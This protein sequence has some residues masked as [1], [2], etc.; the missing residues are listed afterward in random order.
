M[1]K[2]ENTTARQAEI[3][4]KAQELLQSMT[5]PQKLGQIMAMFAGGLI[6]SSILEQFTCGLGE[7]ALL[8]TPDGKEQTARD[9]EEIQKIV[10]SACGLPAIVHAEALTG[11]LHPDATI[12]PSAIGLGA[13]WDTGLVER[14]TE[15]IRVQMQAVGIYQ[16][17]SPV[18]DVARDPRWGRVGETYGEDP[19]LCAAMSVAFTKGLQGKPG[20]DGVIA[21]GKHFLG[22]AM[23]QAGLN[24]AANSIPAR[25]LREIYAKP[26]QAAITEAGLDSVMNSYGTIDNEMVIGSKKIL[27]DL[28]RDE[29]GFE[30]IVVSDYMSIDRMVDLKTAASPAEGGIRALEAGLDSE[31][32][33]PFGYGPELLQAIADGR[34]DEKYLDRAVS[35]I[36]E[37]KLKYGLLEKADAKTWLQ[38]QAFDVEKTRAAS[39]EA[40]RKSIVLLKND[41]ILPLKKEPQTI[42]LIGPHADSLR[43]L[44]GCYTYPAQIDRDMSGSMADMPGMVGMAGTADNAYQMSYLEGCS[45]R[46]TSPV[47]EQTLQQIYG[48]RTPTLLKS[49]KDKCPEAT[50]LYEKGCEVAGTDRSGFEAALRAAKQ[51][52]IMIVCMGGKYGWGTNCTTGE[53][54]DCDR[55]GL[56]GVQEELAQLLCET[57]TPAVFV[58]MDAKPLCSEW[59]A[60]NYPAVIENWFPGETGGEALMDVLFGD[61]NPAGRLP[62]TAPRNE[63]QIPIFHASQN[64]SGYTPG[65]GMVISKYVEGTKEPLFYF[66]EGLSYTTFQYANLDV[67][68]SVEPDGIV[69]ISAEITNT[70]NLA[71]D[72]VVQLYVSDEVASMVRPQKEL[73]GFCR[74]SLQPGQTKKVRFSMKASQF[75]FLNKDMQWEVEEGIMTVRV[76]GSSKELP[77]SG[78]FEISKSAIVD[79]RTRGFYANALVD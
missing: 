54:I 53:G 8:I 72:E 32:P 42:A 24:M 39:L 78:T 1:S 6:P 41:G 63:G 11:L 33:K 15:I 7:V 62:I 51:A 73:A 5:L 29:M 18:M 55:I 77:L 30:G 23:G 68:E 26:F 20:E 25:E 74:I 35:R 71:G 37:I 61:Y 76:G 65:G 10:T 59:I 34:L 70:G 48:N 69:S 3:R 40:A 58:H 16:A 22:Y 56:T 14:M 67:N 47:I 17:L 44:F 12:F 28:L 31:L 9:V 79:G 50:L 49:M 36:L 52:D 2:H 46:G 43:L 21:T 19:T 64:G 75:A 60:T 13:S 4:A 57:G 38:K 66:G 45:V 27:T